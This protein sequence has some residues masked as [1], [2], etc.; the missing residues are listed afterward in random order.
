MEE[1]SL[2][3]ALVVAGDHVR[4]VSAK[5]DRGGKKG[6]RIIQRRVRRATVPERAHL[7]AAS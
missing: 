1:V 3:A 2:S 6:I 4:R 5:G 7:V